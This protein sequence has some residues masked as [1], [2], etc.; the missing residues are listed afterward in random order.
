[1]LAN[2]NFKTRMLFVFLKPGN[3]GMYLRRVIIITLLVTWELLCATK[4]CLAP[5]LNL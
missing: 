4:A 2:H 1:M 5:G 3:K